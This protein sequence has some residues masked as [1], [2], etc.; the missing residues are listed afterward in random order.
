MDFDI[1]VEDIEMNHWVAYVFELFGC[2]SSGRTQDEAVS[3][4]PTKIH[5]YLAA[6]QWRIWTEDGWFLYTTGPYEVAKVEIFRSHPAAEDVTYLVN[7]FF[8]DDARP[9][10]NFDLTTGWGVL[11]EIH[12]DLMKLVQALPAERLNATIAGDTRFGSIAGILKHVANTEWWYCDRLGL[13]EVG[14]ALPDHPLKALEVARANTIL[15]LPE[16]VEDARVVE[17]TG[18][19]WSGRKVLRR[20]LWHERDHTEH[21]RRLLAE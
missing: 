6:H 3:G 17:R 4:V 21:I 12:D 14:A 20:A 13:V 8:E 7:A 2:F 9:L 1:G 10:T 18:E 16:L 11:A 19:R 5:E 15:R